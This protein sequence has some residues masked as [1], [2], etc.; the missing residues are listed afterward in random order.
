M[1][2]YFVFEKHQ[3]HCS[4]A[5]AQLAKTIVLKREITSMSRTSR[6]GLQYCDYVNILKQF[7]REERTGNWNLHLSSIGNMINFFTATG[8]VHCAKTARLYLQGMCELPEKLPL[9]YEQFSKKGL[10]SVRRS[11][12]YWAGLSSCLLIAQVQMGSIKPEEDS[13]EEEEVSLILCK[14]ST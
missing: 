11:D 8:H 13:R 3:D 2:E 5:F 7:I 4:A 9:V 14:Q 10:Y 12:R 1:V 6:L